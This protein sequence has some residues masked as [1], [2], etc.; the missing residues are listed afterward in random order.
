LVFVG[1]ACLLVQTVDHVDELWILEELNADEGNVLC[2]I[3]IKFTRGLG[4]VLIFIS[5][6]HVRS[7]LRDIESARPT[8]VLIEA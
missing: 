3:L 6:P 5:V 4:S 7:E 1:L 2:D 8:Q